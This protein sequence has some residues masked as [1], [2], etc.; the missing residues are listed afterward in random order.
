M[1][2]NFLDDILYDHTIN[3]EFNNVA[4]FTNHINE[5]YK[6]CEDYWKP[7]VNISMPTKD[8]KAIIDRTFNSWDLFVKRLVKEKYYLAD[9]ISKYSYKYAYMDNS[10][11][12]KIYDRL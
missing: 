2:S 10:E 4:D 6:I 8:V 1:M 11:L 3:A 5:L 7:Q 12:K 9:Y